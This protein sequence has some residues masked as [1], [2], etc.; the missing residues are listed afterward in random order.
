M[1]TI[2]LDH[3]ATTALHRDVLEKMLPYFCE[4]YGNADSPHAIGRKAMNA[5]DNAR[6]TVARLIHAK[7]SEVYF[8]SGG[9]EADNWALRGGSLAGREKGRTRVLVSAVEH[10]A[11]LESA[12]Q[13]EKEGFTVDYLPVNEGGMV[14]LSALQAA[15]S[16]DV[17]I[18]AVMAANNET[19]ALQKIADLAKIAHENGALFFTDGVQFAP[20]RKIDVKALGVDMLSMSAHKFYGPKAVGA[21]YIKSGVKTERLIVGGEQERG[22]R[23]GT[24]NVAGVVGLAAAYEKT[25]AELE[26]T[27]EKIR[28]L[29]TLFLDGIKGLDGITQNGEESGLPAVLNLRV[30]GVENA[31]LVYALDLQGVCI[32]AGSACASAS[33]KP[34]HVLQSIGLTE[35]QA[36]QSVRIS[37]GKDNTEEEMVSAA[38][39]FTQTVL[40]LRKF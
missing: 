9:T 39:I 5:V 33:I 7:P 21:L 32:A 40:R 27:D 30:D 14:E 6:D 31:D 2:Y 4:E 18:V 1:R 35:K 34:S 11:V 29:K 15:I 36:K 28:R 13:L 22:L 12:K 26:I 8:T 16:N 23:G 19:G 25:C 38:R 37:F 3:A 10:H 17:A 20:Y 24:T